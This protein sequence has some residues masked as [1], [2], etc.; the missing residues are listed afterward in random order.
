[1]NKNSLLYAAAGVAV[2]AL[3]VGITSYSVGG[4]NQATKVKLD[5]AERLLDTSRGKYT[6]LAQRIQS[7]MTSH[8]LLFQPKREQLLSRLTSLDQEMTLASQELAKAKELAGQNND[9]LRIEIERRVSAVDQRRA[10]AFIGLTELSDLTNTVVKIDE[11]RDQY[12]EEVRRAYNNISGYLTTSVSRAHRAMIDW[13]Q[14][15][16]NLSQLITQVDDV[17]AKSDALWR[18]RSKSITQTNADAFLIWDS[19]QSFQAYG[20]QLARLDSSLG[21]R[22]DQLYVSWDK[23]LV[24]ME[25]KEGANLTLHHKYKTVKVQIQ[26]LQTKQ[27]NYSETENW[28]KVS[29]KTYDQ[30]EKKLGMAIARK[31]AGKF[32]EEAENLAQPAGFS[33]MAPPGKSNRYG[34]WRQDSYGGSF[35]MFYGQ[36]MFMRSMFWGPTYSPIYVNQYNGYRRSHTSGRT[37]YGTTN[38]GQNRYGTNSQATVSRYRSSRFVRGGGY[39]NSYYKRS[40]GNLRGYR[41]SGYQSARSG[42]GGSYRSRGSRSFGGK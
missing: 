35:W 28:E 16:V 32:D 4:L 37:Y 12:V 40:G 25:I 22:V 41:S 39:R 24:D 38:T 15:K 21:Q 31:P 30:L 18:N 8:S 11:N 42:R 20:L 27:A 13:P 34:Q 5:T 1:M 3:L 6:D 9:E 26:D 7:L 33:Y 36:Y 14:K 2:L 29:K 23:I 10:N 19:H 17:K